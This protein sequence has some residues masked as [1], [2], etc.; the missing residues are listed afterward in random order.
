MPKSLKR[1]K[2]L[3]A[4]SA[5]LIVG[6]V[7]RFYGL[8]IQSVWSDELASWYFSHTDGAAQVF[9]RV[10]EDIHP[11]GYFLLLHFTQKFI[12]DSAWALR[13]PS[14]IA[15]WFSIA[16]IYFLGRRI[17]SGREGLIAA[18]FLA[19]FWAP[20]YY[21]QE[22]RSYS[23]LILFSILTTYFWWGLLQ[24][25]RERRTLPIVEALLYVAS[26]MVCAY[27]HYFGAFL[28]ALQGVAL[29]GLAYRSFG[30]V[31]LLYLPVALAYVPWLPRMYYQLT[32]SRQLG[33][34]IP[35]PTPGA[36]VDFFE[37]LFNRSVAPAIIAWTLFAFL[38]PHAWNDLREHKVKSILPGLLLIGWFVVPI[39]LVYVLSQS[40]VHLLTSKNLLISLPAAY[41]LLARS[42]TRT[43]SGRT[44]VTGAI[45]QSVVSVG[46]AA[47]F[48][49]HLLYG[50]Q[51]YTAPHKEQIRAAV[52]YIANNERPGTLVV[53]CDVDPR[54]DYYFQK[55]GLGDTPRV[56]ACNAGEF[57]RLMD[58]VREED[59]RYVVYL[60][61]HKQPDPKLVS[62]LQENFD[63][64][65]DRT[66]SGTE[67]FTLKVRNPV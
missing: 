29:L 4:L 9:Q 43:F 3:L 22:A 55:K 8:S 60:I 16:A 40:S 67:V 39:V 34:W 25:L 47:I 52:S 59:S 17:Y 62:A 6:G 19:V 31:T 11:P 38:V 61:S 30:K 66:F 50:M 64:V 13:L 36:F 44:P 63:V 42:I 21:S 24:N 18:L 45:F 20:V 12:G 10:Q 2:E 65:G 1:K 49:A 58:R 15:G 26:A 23:L 33:G 27:L 28:V 51:Y 14:A 56:S 7:L 53:Y 54:L 41:L 37:F 32:Y 46:I 57:L 5:I 48:L 35:E